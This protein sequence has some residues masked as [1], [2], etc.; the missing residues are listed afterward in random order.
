MNVMV[1]VDNTKERK[2]LVNIA[3]TDKESI[4]VQ[5]L[6][7]ELDKEFEDFE[8][9]MSP[10][11]V[12][13][14]ALVAAAASAEVPKQRVPEA[15]ADLEELRIANEMFSNSFIIVTLELTTLKATEAVRDTA[16]PRMPQRLE[17]TISHQP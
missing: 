11:P 9:T 3:A 17:H 4:E 1:T 12:T 13:T 15:A 10:Y 2:M 8:R 5:R 16:R 14:T 6:E 7:R